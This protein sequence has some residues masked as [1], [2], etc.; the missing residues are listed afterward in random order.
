MM[1]GGMAIAAIAITLLAVNVCAAYFR[2]APAANPS[3][4][5][6]AVRLGILIF[7]IFSFEGILMGG[8]QTHKIGREPQTTFLP[9][10][11]WNMK[12]GDLRVAH[13]IGMHALQ[14]IPLFSIYLFKNTVAVFSLSAIY[15]LF[16]FYVLVQA[17]QSKPFIRSKKLQHETVIGE[18]AIPE[19]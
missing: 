16:A 12:E 18:K 1:F 8:R 2:D 11:K 5:N 9:F 17:L 3:Y 7:V 15:L 6:W 19:K 13:F 10:L 4:Y 14:I